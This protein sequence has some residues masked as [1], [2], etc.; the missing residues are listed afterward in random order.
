MMESFPEKSSAACGGGGI[1]DSTMHIPHGQPA[2][3]RQMSPTATCE[4]TQRRASFL[5]RN[6][7]EAPLDEGCDACCLGATE[8]SGSK[9][10]KDNATTELP[11]LSGCG[12]KAEK[13][14]ARICGTSRSRCGYC[15]GERMH[16]L[17][18]RDAY[19]RIV[20]CHSAKEHNGDEEYPEA[21]KTSEHIDES[22][23]SKSYGL[24]FD[25]IPY[26]TYEG[27]ISRGTF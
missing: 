12:S 15:G 24:L 13:A 4:P 26:V 21:V 5:R 14:L 27:L 20:V 18:V 8:R 9:Q 17:S 1:N 10:Q 22:R 6:S 7:I 19:N 16:V 23:T 11:R 2:D 25:R 3:R